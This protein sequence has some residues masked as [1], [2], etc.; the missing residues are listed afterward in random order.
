MVGIEKDRLK[1][2]TVFT[3]DIPDEKLHELC[4]AVK[5]AVDAAKEKEVTT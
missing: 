2:K 1:I 3:A 4:E 5:F